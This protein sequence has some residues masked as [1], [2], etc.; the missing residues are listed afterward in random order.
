MS[1][2]SKQSL[3]LLHEHRE[4]VQARARELYTLAVV[5]ELSFRMQ[6][7]RQ[8]LHQLFSVSPNAACVSSTVRAHDNQNLIIPSGHA[9]SSASISPTDPTLDK[10]YD[11]V[12]SGTRELE[13]GDLEGAK[14]LYQESLGVKETASGWFNLGVSYHP[15]VH[16]IWSSCHA[17]AKSQGSQLI[18]GM[19]VSPQ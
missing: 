9:S 16:G 4:Q 8:P 17:L 3:V 14:K 12:E 19:R 5:L 13:E 15:H 11:L 18:A 1:E 6:L 7:D 2:P 10:A